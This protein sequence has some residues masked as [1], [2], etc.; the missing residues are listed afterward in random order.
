[1]IA[2]ADRDL[3]AGFFSLEAL[4]S[5][6]REGLASR[7]LPD[8]FEDIPRSLFVPAVDLDRGERVVFGRGEL[9][10]VPISQA[11]AASS[12]IPGFFE[13]Y[14]IGGHTYVDGGVGF[15][16]H[17][18]IAAEAGAEI[19][20]VIYPMVPSVP[21]GESTVLPARGLYGVMDQVGRIYS[22]NLLRLGLSVLSIKFPKTKFYLLEPPRSA[23]A[24]FGPS[25]GF[26]A[27]RAA[28]RFGYESTK[29]WLGNEGSPLLDGLRSTRL[30]FAP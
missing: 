27:S 25:M 29:V 12:A 1:M 8:R 23:A 2:R 9:R 28:L 11:V 7:G 5:F 6:V 13:P 21:D 17:A 20:F 30:A 16:D 26:E 10:D 15:T 19:V 24:M 3:P 14:P 22:N 18:D 4:E